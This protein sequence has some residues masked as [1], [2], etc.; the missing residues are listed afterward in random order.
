[1]RSFVSDVEAGVHA[2]QGWPNTC[3]GTSKIGVIA[4]TRFLARDEPSIIFNA[5]DPG[6]CATDQNNNAGTLP[7]ATG[8]KT[9]IALATLATDS[10]FKKTTGKFFSYTGAEI[11]WLRT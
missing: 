2:K 3:Y 10:S 4:M 6:Y 1:M 11:D 8:A 9:P 7:A 5:V